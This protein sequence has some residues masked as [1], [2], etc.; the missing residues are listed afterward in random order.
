M[1]GS[2][3]IVCLPLND[4]EKRFLLGKKGTAEMLAIGLNPSRANET[5]LDPTSRNIERIAKNNGCDGWWLVN[6]Y[7][8]RTPKPKDLPKTPN[9]KLIEQNFRF[10]EALIQNPEYKIKKVVCCW[11]N[12][13]DDHLYLEQ[14]ALKILKLFKEGKVSCYSIGIT[15]S[16]NPFHPAPMCVNRFLGGISQIRL[17]PYS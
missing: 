15:Q 10:I 17:K 1:M 2:S 12:H 11:G 6:L 5:K 16:G 7:P 13:I 9:L 4:P 14:Q 8:K 3:N